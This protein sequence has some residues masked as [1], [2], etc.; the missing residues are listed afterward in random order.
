[1]ALGVMWRDWKGGLEGR[2]DWKEGGGGGIM[3]PHPL[4]W[5]RPEEIPTFRSCPFTK[6]L[7]LD[8]SSFRLLASRTLTSPSR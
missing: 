4:V 2:G 8:S 5:G 6:A 1:M 7:P 3:T